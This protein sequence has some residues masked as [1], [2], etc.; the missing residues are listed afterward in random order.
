MTEPSYIPPG[1]R[2]A[3]QDD[4]LNRNRAQGTPQGV[5]QMQ[6]VWSNEVPQRVL[7][8]APEPVHARPQATRQVAGVST[9]GQA[10]P[11]STAP[12]TSAARF[13]QVGT[14]GV[15]E[16]ANRAAGRL[17]SLGL[18]VTVV[19]STLRGKPVQIV[20]AGPFA[21][22]DQASAALHAARGAGFG[23]AVLRH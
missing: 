9:K 23:D 21:S 19:R 8:G 18:P 17:Q 13:V 14:F 7:P 12:A 11:R 6:Q 20:R 16:N 3:W 5:A 10:A 15:P 22:P 2:A 1:Y 4:R